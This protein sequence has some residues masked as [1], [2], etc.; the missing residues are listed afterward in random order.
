MVRAWPAPR[1]VRGLR[2]SEGAEAAVD[3]AHRCLVGARERSDGAAHVLRTWRETGGS[4]GRRP[5][6]ARVRR[7]DA[8]ETRLRLEP[9][10]VM[11]LAVLTGLR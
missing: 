10:G 1:G 6:L 11:R 4:E 3:P 2:A 5:Q 7:T 8:D 9:F